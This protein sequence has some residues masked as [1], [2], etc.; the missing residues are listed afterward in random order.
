M[1][2]SLCGMCSDV[3]LAFQHAARTVLLEDDSLLQHFKFE[4]ATKSDSCELSYHQH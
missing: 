2:H 1:M 3:N 4:I